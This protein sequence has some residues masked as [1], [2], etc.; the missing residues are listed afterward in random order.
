MMDQLRGFVTNRGFILDEKAPMVPYQAPEGH[1]MLCLKRGY[2]FALDE[3]AV[4]RWSIPVFN[5]L[6]S[7]ASD[8]THVLLRLDRSPVGQEGALVLHMLAARFCWYRDCWQL[9]DTDTPWVDLTATMEDDLWMDKHESVSH[10][11]N[12]CFRMTIYSLHPLDYGG[13]GSKAG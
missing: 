4:C 2:E 10:M 7:L 3:L 5:H 11:L 12:D 1:K 8:S 6:L 13:L 9:C